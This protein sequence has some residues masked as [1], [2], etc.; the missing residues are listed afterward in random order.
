[1]QAAAAA[2]SKQYG[3]EMVGERYEAVLGGAMARW[4]DRHAVRALPPAWHR[5][6]DALGIIT[7]QL[8]AEAGALLLFDG[9]RR[10]NLRTGWG[11]H[12]DDVNELP[13][14]AARAVARS[15]QHVIVNSGSIESATGLWAD[16]A[17]SSE[18]HMPL[19]AG[20]GTRAVVSLLRGP[21]QPVWQ[22]RDVASVFNAMRNV[23]TAGAFVLKE[24]GC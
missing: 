13:E 2:D 22:D 6:F 15:Q 5:P 3:V 18:L 11:V 20:F 17:G 16:L 12:V 8:G 23:D 4:R 21:H 9:T 19:G 7:A 1:M 14:L 24:V 10:A